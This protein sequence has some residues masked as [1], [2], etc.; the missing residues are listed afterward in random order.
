ML[1]VPL[2]PNQSINWSVSQSINQSINRTLVNNLSEGEPMAHKCGRHILNLSFALILCFSHGNGK[3]FSCRG[4]SLVI[5]HFKQ[6]GHEKV[7]ALVPQWRCQ[8]PTPDRPISDHRLLNIL[9]D[10]GLLTF[11]P[12]RRI[13]NRNISCYDDRYALP[14]E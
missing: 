8:A 6:R 9:K 4:I 3:I 1:K 13:R 10:E 12:S 7:V 5:N 11:T 2:N 14:S